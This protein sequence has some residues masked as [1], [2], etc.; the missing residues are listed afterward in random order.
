MALL[1]ETLVE[2]WLNRNRF[3]TMR[4]IKVGVDEIDLLAICKTDGGIEARHYEVQVSTNPIS[5]ISK[6]T[7]E[8]SKELGKARGSAF[9]REDSVLEKSVEE[10]VEKKFTSKK[11]REVRDHLCPGVE[12][13]Y[14]FVH[15]NVRHPTELQLIAG[16]QIE[17][18]PFQDVLKELCGNKESMFKGGSGSDLVEIMSFL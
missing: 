7:A 11:K 17:L 16:H 12:W 3:F 6:L 2:E 13:K 1:A 5:Y 10:W 4:G 18:I 14:Y 8:Q 15:G 9:S